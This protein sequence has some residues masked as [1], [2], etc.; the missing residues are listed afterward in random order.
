MLYLTCV[1]TP[2]NGSVVLESTL[3]IY[4][5]AHSLYVNNSF[6]L[7]AEEIIQC[8]VK[9]ACPKIAISM[10]DNIENSSSTSVVNKKLI[11]YDI[12]TFYN[13]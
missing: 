12:L 3:T 1:T 9:A 2:Q 13:C 5:N 7:S 4:K 11:N 8:M 6:C 10:I